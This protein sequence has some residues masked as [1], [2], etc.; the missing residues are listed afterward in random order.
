MY[1]EVFLWIFTDGLDEL[2]SLVHGL[3]GVVIERAILD[4]L[5]D[6][7]FAFIDVGQYVVQPC[8]GVIEPMR[9][10]GVLGEL[11]QCSFSLVDFC[12]QLVRI[13]NG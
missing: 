7:S 6:R 2:L 5:A 10:G 1:D 4:Q 12:K 3:V 11:S 8:D 9:K 13:G